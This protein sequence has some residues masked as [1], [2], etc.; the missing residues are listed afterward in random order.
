MQD[1][2]VQAEAFP[3]TSLRGRQ[4]RVSSFLLQGRWLRPSD[5]H[6]AGP[7]QARAAGSGSAPSS[8]KHRPGGP[9]G[10]RLQGLRLDVPA[11]RGRTIGQAQDRRLSVPVR[12]VLERCWPS[13]LDRTRPPVWGAA[14]SQRGVGQGRW[15]KLKPGDAG[16]RR[17]LLHG[18]DD[19]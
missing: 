10:R 1:F 16:S 18:P 2:N 19:L 7:S 8:Q 14:A 13:R 6:T 3:E 17:L 11:G 15:W 9:S 12:R 5:D 4:R